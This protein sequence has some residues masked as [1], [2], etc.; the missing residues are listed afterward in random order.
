[1]LQRERP[2]PHTAG[3]RVYYIPNKRMGEGKKPEKLKTII[4]FKETKFLKCKEDL[5]K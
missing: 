4:F 3:N 2:K 1:M 5:N